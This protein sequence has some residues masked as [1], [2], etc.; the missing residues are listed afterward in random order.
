MTRNQLTTAGSLQVG[1]RFYKLGDKKK[2][3]FQMIAHE[4]KQTHF[5]TYKLFCCPAIAMDNKLMSQKLKDYQIKPIIKD[6]KVVY[7]KNVND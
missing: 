4:A 7:L 3:V 1:D 2:E 5:R 6:T